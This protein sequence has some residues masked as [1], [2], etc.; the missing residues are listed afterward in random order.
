M[1]GTCTDLY[2]IIGNPIKHS[3]SPKLHNAMFKKYNID[4]VYLAFEVNNLK[5]AIEGVKGLNIKGINITLPFKGEAIKYIDSI[6]NEAKIIGSINT[7]KNIKGT[8][9][10]YNTDYLGFLE[11]I[12]DIDCNKNICILGAGGASSACIYAF[13]KKGIKSINIYNRTFTKAFKLKEYFKDL[14][15]LN[16]IE[17][18]DIYKNEIIVNTT[19]AGIVGNEKIIDLNLL[20][21][22][23]LLV[24][25]LYKSDLIKEAKSFGIKGIDGTKMFI[26]QAF[27]AF[28]IW[29]GIEFDIN[30]AFEVVN[31]SN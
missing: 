10:G 3:L 12:K 26:Y 21:K 11:T 14:I 2:A 30:Y 27:Y 6:E 17:K 25:I 24:D 19:S 13:Y 8:L 18:K 28:N 5:Y 23:A 29:T 9:F 1:I 4:A 15:A 16:I 31:G 22:S 20:N 7:V